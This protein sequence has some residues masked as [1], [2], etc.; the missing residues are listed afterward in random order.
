MLAFGSVGHQKEGGKGGCAT[1]GLDKHG[2]NVAAATFRIPD[3]TR[4]GP[5]RCRCEEL[6]GESSMARNAQQI[7][8]PLSTATAMRNEWPR[9]ALP[10]AVD[11]ADVA[12]AWSRP[13]GARAEQ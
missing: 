3:R 10:A 12:W 1:L 9:R 5:T 2:L 8:G 7:A 11:A 6:R 4:D 13:T